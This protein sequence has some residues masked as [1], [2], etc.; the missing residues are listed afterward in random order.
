[1]AKNL[2][3]V[4]SPA[5][6]K[7]IEKFLGKDYSVKS[8]FGHV[9][10]LI[11]KDFG[12]EIEN[13]FKPVY[14]IMPDKRKVVSELRKE[15]KNAETVILASDEDREGEAIAWHLS[16]VLKLNKNNTKR[17]V[18]NEITKNAIVEAVNN[19]RDID[20]D[21]VNAQQARRILDRLVGFE[22]SSVLWKKVKPSLSAG[23]VQSV[24]VR[25]IVER[26]REIF[27]FKEKTFF[28]VYGLFSFVDKK[29]ENYSFKAELSENLEKKEDVITFFEKYG[30]N[31]YKV[32]S[33]EKK[34]GKKSP[35]APFTT[36]SL[37][38][39]A[40]RKLGFPV[41]KTMRVA[42]KLYEAG[43]ITYMRTDSVNLSD[44]ALDAA[45][46]AVIN[47]FGNDYYKKRTYKTKSKGAQE[48][49]EAIR[50]TYFENK[51]IE[52][53]YDERRLYDLIRK[54]ALSSQM[55]DALF[56][57]TNVKINVNNSELYFAVSG[58]VSV[59][60]GFLRAY[61]T[62]NDD[63]SET[64]E[65]LPPLTLGE[66]LNVI[67]I[68]GVQKFSKHPARYTEAGLVKKLEEQGIGRPST[69]APTISTIQNR[70]YVVKE[71]REGDK[72]QYLSIIYD[73]K[74]TENTKSEITGAEKSKLF[75]TD[76]G[77]VVTDFLIDNFNDV[78]DYNFTANVEDQFDVISVGKLKWQKMIGDFYS[79]FH[80]QVEKT[81]QFTER[82]TGERILGID[83]E[84]GKEVSVRIGRFGPV[85]QL[86]NQ[87]DE[88]K[89]RF[90]SL[91]KDQHIE[92]ITLEE[93][94][95][96]IKN[97]ASGRLLGVDPESGKNV[98][99]RLARYGAIVQIGEND[100]KEKPRFA[101]L[102][103]GMSLETVNL[104]QALDLFKLPREVGM[105]ENKKVV[106]AVGRFGPYLSHDSK[107]TSLK[108][109]DNP[110]TVKLER[111]IELIVEKREKDKK[112]LIKEF[113]GNKDII[114]IKDRWGRP[115][116]FTNKQYFNISDIKKPENLTLEDC[117][118]I[119]EN[120]GG[121]KTKST[122]KSTKGEK[123]STSKKK[124]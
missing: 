69:Y 72:R 4:E 94:T 57:K 50:P 122:K 80:S 21:L 103:S 102:L 100:D 60:D 95:D 120:Q 101:G 77:M 111:A 113:P 81:L 36:S 63:D 71:D 73:G 121:I 41:S 43:M 45:K 52:G 28:K 86:G 116:I 17:I 56:E 107:F 92:T 118:K 85:A 109:D 15:V 18:F 51:N 59:F 90:A 47:D 37:Q 20:I 39:E 2:V 27:N 49:H 78:I 123:K 84:T 16:E 29:G 117:L 53:S 58:E 68:E 119:I 14:E 97:S 33:I 3:I 46:T 31:I 54:R 30:K 26:E 5:K 114:I 61:E 83:K 11:K 32:D 112:K 12:I 79:K 40:A 22:L 82:N 35:S 1:M 38:Q 34:P 96:L 24:A 64:K 13:D 99:A 98:Y 7:T 115:C 87:D 70:G 62:V 6:A 48:A 42:Q 88:E 105:F 67:N 89:P 23:R 10:D 91:Q 108:K 75:P 55:S 106:A 19:P 9:R 44:F 104:E 93:A 66:K 124:K 74:I 8:S 65:T 110:L 76:I 25:I